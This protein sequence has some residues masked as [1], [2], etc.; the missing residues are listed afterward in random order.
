MKKLVTA[1]TPLELLEDTNDTTHLINHVREDFAVSADFRIAF[2]TYEYHF[3][4]GVDKALIPE[5]IGYTYISGEKFSKV[6]VLRMY[7]G[8]E[9]VSKYYASLAGA[10][11]VQ[12]K[13][14][15]VARLFRKVHNKK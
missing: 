9:L 13:K 12:A 6:D 2:G 14:G 8:E 4:I 3:N 5:N 7:G 10:K 15:S 1:F 11:P